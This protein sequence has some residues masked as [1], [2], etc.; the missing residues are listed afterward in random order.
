MPSFAQNKKI[1]ADIKTKSNNSNAFMLPW[2]CVVC[3]A[4][5]ILLPVA[6]LRTSGVMVKIVGIF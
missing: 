6:F 4:V 3:C 2:V 5:F 1:D